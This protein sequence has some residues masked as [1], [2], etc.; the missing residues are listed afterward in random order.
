MIQILIIILFSLVYCEEISNTAT[1]NT[2]VIISDSKIEDINSK[3]KSI[4]GRDNDPKKITDISKRQLFFRKLGW[5]I[6]TLPG[7]RFMM[8]FLYPEST[9]THFKV[10][11]AVAF[12]IDDGFCGLDNSDGCMLE[13]VR[14]LFS[15][16]D[17]HATFFIAGSHCQHVSIEEVNNLISDGHEIANHNIMDWSYENYTPEDFEYDLL[18]TKNILS[19]YNQDYSHWYRAPFGKLTNNIETVINKHNMTHVLP[20]AFAHDSFIPDPNW[21]AKHILKKVKP[22]SVILIHMPE[23]GVREWNYKAMELTL[24]GLKEKKYSILNLS[25]IKALEKNINE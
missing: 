4:L 12:T 3:Y 20:D 21:I 7:L 22:G 1:Q 16:Y 8:R 9:V 25:E 17:A 6:T 19:N 14:Q 13:E 2:N 11:N 15:K 5:T 24:K 10:N 18:L 23:K